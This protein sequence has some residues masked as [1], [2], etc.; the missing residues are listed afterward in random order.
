MGGDLRAR[1]VVIV[2]ADVAMLSAE[3]ASIDL[4]AA[5]GLSCDRVVVRDA[6]GVLQDDVWERP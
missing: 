4:W 6:S 1:E 3:E 2:L 5:L